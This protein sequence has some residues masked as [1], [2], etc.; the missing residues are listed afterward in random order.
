MNIQ[1]WFPLELS[2]LFSL[3]SKG[4]S[5]VFPSTT[6]QMWENSGKIEISS[7]LE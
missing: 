7:F 6:I 2:G 3:L 4:L 1:N 5:R